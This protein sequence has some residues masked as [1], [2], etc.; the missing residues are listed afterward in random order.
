MY[1]Q[2]L[3]AVCHISGNALS[4]LQRLLRHIISC[5]IFISAADNLLCSVT[6]APVAVLLVLVRFALPWLMCWA[7]RSAGCAD[8]G[9]APSALLASDAV[10][11]GVSCCCCTGE[12]VLDSSLCCLLGD[13]WFG[14]VYGLVGKG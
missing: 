7:S 10:C 4:G 8:A 9:S 6:D 13:R 2:K 12:M 11:A 5:L 1:A 14:V 3:R